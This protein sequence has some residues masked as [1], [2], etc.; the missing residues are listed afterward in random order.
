[1]K[2]QLTKAQTK[3]EQFIDL[4]MKGVECWMQAGELVAAAI[5]EN[6]NFVDEVCDKCPDI[7]P[8]MVYRVEAIGRKKL[9]PRLLLNDTPGTRRLR[10]LPYS[11]QEKHATEPVRVL[12]P[13][14]DTLQ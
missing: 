11:L 6:A 13:D 5:D 10:N 14:G 9:H 2:E 4:V 1:M 3:A 12:L 8:E 7:S